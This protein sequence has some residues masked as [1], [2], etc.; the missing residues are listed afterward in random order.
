[1]GLQIPAGIKLIGC[2][3]LAILAFGARTLPGLV[4]LTAANITAIYF[5]KAGPADIWRETRR[6]V[7]WQT[8]I[9]VALYLIRF[10][11]DGL[12]PGT[13]TSWQLFLAYLP[14]IIFMQSTPHA[15]IVETL[16]RVLPDKTAFVLA[17]CIRFIP[18]MIGEI[19]TI[20]EA[21]L[22]RGA[23][24]MPRDL[25]RPWHWPDLIHCLLVPVIVQSLHL[26]E[27]IA[28]AARARDFGLK[29]Q[30][31]SWPGA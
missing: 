4:L 23:R 14:G 26:S 13:R 29:P 25:I 30:R 10:G 21:Q 15:R 1:M 22:L 20:H 11:I 3:I 19:K 2:M 7:F 8:G 31:T 9:I 5:L 27:Q 17:T 12:W 18:L 28:R 24:I 6:V 16:T